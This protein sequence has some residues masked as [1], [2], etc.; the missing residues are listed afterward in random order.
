M[1]GNDQQKNLLL[2]IPQLAG[3]LKLVPPQL[4]L[5]LHIKEY[6]CVIAV[7]DE[8]SSRVERYCKCIV[9]INIEVELHGVH[10]V[11]RIV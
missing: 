6:C 9:E 7:H 10:S 3:M 1:Y 8:Q 2:G 5:T 11:G 4:K